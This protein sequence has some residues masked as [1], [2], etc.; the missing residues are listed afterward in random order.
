MSF[1]KTNVPWYSSLKDFFSLTFPSWQWKAAVRVCKSRSRRHH[2]RILSDFGYFWVTS[3]TE[4][5]LT[6]LEILLFHPHFEVYF[7]WLLHLYFCTLGSNPENVLKYFISS[8]FSQKLEFEPTMIGALGWGFEA[9]FPKMSN[10]SLFRV[11]LAHCDDVRLQVRFP[12]AWLST[13]V[14]YIC[15]YSI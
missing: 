6:T 12:F 7:M 11:D 4:C 14:V 1:V 8:V 5:Q 9:R 2:R 10:L 3:G 13:Y 15:I